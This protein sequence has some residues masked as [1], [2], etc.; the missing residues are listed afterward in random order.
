MS[1]CRFALDAAWF[2]PG[3]ATQDPEVAQAQVPVRVGVRLLALDADPLATREK[4][5]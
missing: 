1:V 3:V 4:S 2:R 5:D